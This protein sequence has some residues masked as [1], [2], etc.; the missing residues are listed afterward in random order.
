[1]KV[2]NTVRFSLLTLAFIASIWALYVTRDIMAPFALAVFIWLIIDAF[3]RWMDNL[4][5]KFPYWLAL[6]IAILT[7]VFGFVGIIMI[8]ADTAGDVARE[9]PR[10]DIRIQEILHMVGGW[11]GNPDLN[12]A[13][14]DEQ[15]KIKDN[16]NKGIAAFAGSIQGVLS[17]F[18]II[19]LYVIFLFVAQSGFS[20]KMDNIFLEGERRDQANKVGGRIRS[21]IET[22]LGVQ[23]MISLIQ[24]VLSYAVMQA[25]GLENALFWA[26][27]IFVFNY[28]PV[29][30]GI[31]ATVLPALFALV[32]FTTFWPVLILFGLLNVIQTGISNTIQPKMM[33]DSMNLS[34]LVVI[35]ALILWGSLWG[36]VGAFLSAPLT[37]IMMIVFAEFKTMRPIAI[38]LSADGDPTYE[39]KRKAKEKYKKDAET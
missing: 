9:A 21:S 13:D 4:S 17:N 6:T 30:G 37:V 26:L 23:T 15:F 29:I 22:Y 35:L 20:K 36:G 39:P 18:S 38:L 2:D 1:M 14:I 24:T 8:I 16:L 33:G 34:A 12:Y 11:F 32:Q 25:M 19:A 27:V 10:Y 28:I 3:A 7:I 5:P 31:V